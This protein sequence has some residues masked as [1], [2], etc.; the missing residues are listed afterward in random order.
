M[1]QFEIIKVRSIVTF[2]RLHS[3]L[4]SCKATLGEWDKNL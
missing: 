2:I 1:I 4:V 3:I